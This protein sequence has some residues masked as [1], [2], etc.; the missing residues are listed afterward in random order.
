MVHLRSISSYLPS[1]LPAATHAYCSIQV[2]VLM[3]TKY[4][5]TVTISAY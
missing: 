5:S 2:I 4:D 1:N 3:F